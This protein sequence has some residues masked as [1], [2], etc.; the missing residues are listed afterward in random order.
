[1]FDPA[2]FVVQKAK[3]LPVCLLLDVSSSMS[4]EKIDSLNKAVRQMMD[5]FSQEE[6][7]ETEI[8]VSVI[9]F[10]NEARLQIPFAKASDIQW[11]DLKVNGNTPMGDALK[12]AKEMIED[13]ET[14]PSRAYRPTIVLVSDGQ[15]TDSW[16]RPLEDFIKG[17]AFLKV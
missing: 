8:L 6:K 4:G 10:G 3:P 1:M 11:A 14:T 9:T 17:G 15:P 12:M 13:K 16:E 2:K 5:T 7:L